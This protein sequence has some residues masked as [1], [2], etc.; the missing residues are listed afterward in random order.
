V[1]H[2]GIDLVLIEKLSKRQLDPYRMLAS[3]IVLAAGRLVPQKD[4]VTLIQAFAALQQRRKCTLV[5]LGDGPAESAVRAMVKSLKLEKDVV[6]AGHVDNPY[7]YMS[8]ADCFVLS[9]RFEGFGLVLAE[10]LAC[11]CPVVSTDCPSGPREILDNGEYGRLVPVGD[12]EELASA[13]YYTL[14]RL[15]NRTALKARAAEFS[16]QRMVDHYLQLL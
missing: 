5:I 11:G 16:E 1:I 7:A 14:H 3:P 8:R 15:H 12:A 10:A 2:N 4:Y 9:S 6:L 13:M